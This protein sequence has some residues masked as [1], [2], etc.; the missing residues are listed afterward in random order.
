[1]IQGLVE[2]PSAALTW[3]LSFQYDVWPADC[4]NQFIKVYG[5][6]VM[7]CSVKVRLRFG[8]WLGQ[9]FSFC[10]R[11]AAVLWITLHYLVEAESYTLSCREVDGRLSDCMASRRQSEPNSSALTSYMLNEARGVWDGKL[12]RLATV[13]SF[14]HVLNILSLWRMMNY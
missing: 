10:Y 11:L 3:G 5:Y 14:L 13:W 8:L 4:C 9:F 2:S 12:E 1:M 6:L 7:H